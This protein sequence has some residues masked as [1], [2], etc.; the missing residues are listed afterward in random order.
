MKHFNPFCNNQLLYKSH[1]EPFDNDITVR[2][3]PADRNRGS[4]TGHDN[5]PR[6]TREVCENHTD[7]QRQDALPR[8]CRQ[9]CRGGIC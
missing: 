7:Q 8:V 4:G 5:L 6:R 2:R 1:Y 3:H 9:T